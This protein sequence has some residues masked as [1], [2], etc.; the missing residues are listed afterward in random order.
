M[1]R[2]DLDI[3]EFEILIDN[4]Q[5]AVRAQVLAEIVRHVGDNSEL[6]TLESERSQAFKLLYQ[7]ISDVISLAEEATKLKDKR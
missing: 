6:D 2:I 4:L 5:R 7:A 3:G 1:S